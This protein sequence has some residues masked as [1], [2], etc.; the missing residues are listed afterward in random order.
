[1]SDMPSA[2]EAQVNARKIAEA[3]ILQLLAEEQRPLAVDEIVQYLAEPIR[4]EEIL[5]HLGHSIRF[6]DT[7]F[8]DESVARRAILRLAA[9]G[10]AAVDNNFKL[11]PAKAA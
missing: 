2:L 11:L 4:A 8:A 10:R 5:S 6:V 1:M 3:A 7:H 9:T